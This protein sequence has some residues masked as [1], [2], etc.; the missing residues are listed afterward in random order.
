MLIIIILIYSTIYLISSLIIN[1]YD[2]NYKY[3]LQYNI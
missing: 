1:I 2:M 3:L